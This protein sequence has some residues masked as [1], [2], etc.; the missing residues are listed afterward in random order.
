[1]P[2]EPS[3]ATAINPAAVAAREYQAHKERTVMGTWEPA[4]QTIPAGT[5]AV[6]M[7]QPLARL[8]FLVLEPRA[9]DSF[10]RWNLMDEVIERSKIYPI[11]RSME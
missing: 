8:I 7:N 10:V 5:L 6:P 9:E 11:F 4:E 1:M 2:Y 3:P